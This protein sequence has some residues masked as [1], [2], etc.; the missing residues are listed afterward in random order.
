MAHMHFDTQPLKTLRR[1]G[2]L[3]I[4]SLTRKPQPTQHFSDAT[5][6]N[7]TDADEVEGFFVFL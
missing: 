1:G 3:R 4:A 6:A 5:H 7:A 2:L